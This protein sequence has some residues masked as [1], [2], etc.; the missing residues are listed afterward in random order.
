[1]ANSLLTTD[2]I[3]D[4]ALQIFSEKATFLNSVNRQY[5]STFNQKA[6]KIGDTLR[7]AVPQHS[8]I[9]SG[10]VAQ[11]TALQTLV[12]P[13]TIQDQTQF[14]VTYNS[15]EMA[16][17]IE[18][19]SRRY[20]DQQ[21][22]DLVVNIESQVQILAYQA[23]PNQ[24]GTPDGQWTNVSYANLARKFIEDN[25]G[26][27]G[28][29]K[30]LINNA[31]EMTLINAQRTYFNPTPEISKQYGDGFITRAS[32][33]DWFSSTVLPLHQ[34]GSANA[35][36]D[37]NGAN[38]TGSEIDIDTGT[39]TILVGD[40]VTFAGCYAVHPQ[41]KVSL[42]Y[43]RQFV[44]TSALSGGTIGIY[45]AITVTGPEQNVTASPTDGGDVT[46]LGTASDTYGVNL[47][48]TPDAFTFVTVDLPDY[49]D[50]PCSRRKFENVSMRVAAGSDITNDTMLM[51][52][53]IMWGFGALRPEWACRVA[54]DPAN[55]TPA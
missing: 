15:S 50:R 54:N 49:P 48:Y 26:F 36:Y 24:T 51:R 13:V 6:P 18:E 12:R 19:F 27:K 14:S 30:M 53:D 41:T 11:P 44:V 3:A 33:F 5:D 43:L 46:I 39:G 37:I 10:R 45:P 7:V 40:V 17:D 9:I 29:K 2:L 31:A 47:A 25:G 8:Q 55:L 20:L 28:T 16:L 21:V 1:M 52:F 23:T 22:A 4:R 35:N 34:R 38:Q 32:G 42:G